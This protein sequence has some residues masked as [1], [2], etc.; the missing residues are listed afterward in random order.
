MNSEDKL[1]PKLLCENRCISDI[2]HPELVYGAYF[3]S[4]NE[5]W[6]DLKA[7]VAV[8]CGNPLFLSGS[9]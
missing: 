7:V 4:F 2:G 3:K 9:T 5:I 6:I 1:C 8:G